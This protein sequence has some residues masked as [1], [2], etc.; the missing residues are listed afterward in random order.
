[1]IHYRK[2]CAANMIKVPEHKQD[3][4]DF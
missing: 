2:Q 3:A 1:M 4:L